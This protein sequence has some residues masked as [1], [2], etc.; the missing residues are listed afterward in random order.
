MNISNELLFIEFPSRLPGLPVSER[1]VY[2]LF[3][4]TIIIYR[5]WL[6]GDHNYAGDLKTI[7]FA[8][9]LIANLRKQ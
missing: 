6:T 5:V 7:Y 1:Q 2:V 4:R 3:K 8:I 9:H